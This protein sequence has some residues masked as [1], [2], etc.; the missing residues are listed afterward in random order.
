MDMGDLL[1]FEAV[2]SPARAASKRNLLAELAQRASKLVDRNEREIFDAV[3]QREKLG[4]TGVGQGIAIPHARLA[5]LTKIAGV[6]ARLDRA[7][8]FEAD[9][10]KPVDLVFL[11]LVP[12]HAGA[13]HLQALSRV[14][15]FLRDASN[16]NRLRATRDAEALFALMTQPNLSAA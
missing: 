10:G 12:E 9:D 8:D 16:A 5:G 2:I 3:M 7:I 11:L 1:T 13:D 14:A 15:R 6:F 4:S